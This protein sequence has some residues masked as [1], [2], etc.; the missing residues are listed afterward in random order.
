[1]SVATALRM[2]RADA[3]AVIEQ[4]W[5]GWVERRGELGQVDTPAYLDRWLFAVSAGQA[6]A[7]LRGF[8][9]LAAVDGG[10]DTDAASV[11]I[12]VMLPA[13]QRLAHRFARYGVTDAQVAAQLWIEVRCYPWRMPG[14]VAPRL[15]GLLRRYLVAASVSERLEVPLSSVT[16]AGA[17]EVPAGR[18]VHC[19]SR[20]AGRA[21]MDELRAVL[22]GGCR[23]G[24]ISRDDQLLLLDVVATA[25]ESLESWLSGGTCEVMGVVSDQVGFSWGVTSRTV[26]RRTAASLQALA[27]HYRVNRAIA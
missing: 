7:V 3:Q 19:G 26:R 2:S 6:D 13:G 12:W 14:R 20:R 23:D 9:F 8:A 5:S 17:D 1:M 22:E 18:L 27:A 15:A 21:A 24:V 16:D 25:S 10:D 11:L 4:R